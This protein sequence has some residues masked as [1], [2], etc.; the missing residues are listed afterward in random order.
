MIYS[1]DAWVLIRTP[2][3]VKV[4]A[5]WRGGY[6]VGSEWRLSS[7]VIKIVDDSKT[8]QIFNHSGSIYYCVKH[9]E[10]VIPIMYDMH[11]TLTDNGCVQIGVSDFAIPSNTH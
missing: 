10:G 2:D 9:Q 5:G 4:L 11:K 6:L 7:G 1:P 3:C 8:Y